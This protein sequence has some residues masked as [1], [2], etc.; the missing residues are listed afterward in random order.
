MGNS[1]SLHGRLE[2]DDERSPDNISRGLGSALSD[3]AT[4]SLARDISPV[5]SE[6][7]EVEGQDLSQSPMQR[8]PAGLLFRGESG[9]VLAQGA[10][11]AQNSDTNPWSMFQARRPN[12]NCRDNEGEAST[13]LGRD[14]DE[15]ARIWDDLVDTPDEF[16][17]AQ[18][19]AQATCSF[20]SSDVSETLLGDEWE[21]EDDRYIKGSA[22]AVAFSD[23]SRPA[24]IFFPWIP[25][26][27]ISDRLGPCRL[28]DLSAGSGGDMQ[29][30]DFYPPVS[31]NYEWMSRSIETLLLGHRA[32]APVLALPEVDRVEIASE[33]TSRLS[34][35]CT[36]R[37]SVCRLD[38]HRSPHRAVRRISASRGASYRRRNS[39]AICADASNAGPNVLLSLLAR[40][41]SY[42]NKTCV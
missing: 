15:E 20:L 8:R 19:I 42:L 23:Y 24:G 13:P 32:A 14:I 33:E 37:T 26:K 1:H 10:L 38:A 7:E 2:D 16:C 39:C 36:R 4:H 17:D 9:S 29:V 11:Q 28:S 40:E 6:P 34:V 31:Q 18:V 41:V 5:V 3:G 22:G 12:Y 25:T 27:M 35:G 21:S 30:I